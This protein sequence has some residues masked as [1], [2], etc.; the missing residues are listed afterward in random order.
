LGNKYKISHQ[1]WYRQNREKQL[2]ASKSWHENNLEKAHD[3][4][5]KYNAAIK[6]DV[7]SRYGPQGKLQCCWPDCTV[8]DPDMLSLD[9]VENN[10]A[11]DR[12]IRGTGVQLYCRLR[13][14]G[15]PEGFQTLCFNHQMKKELMRRRG[16]ND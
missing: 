14:E 9:H 10:G 11:E 15:Y 7:L 3:S 5:R 12:K 8:I 13:K 1:R 6:L 4:S 2:A 16:S